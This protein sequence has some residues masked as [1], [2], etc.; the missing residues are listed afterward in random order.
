MAK[1]EELITGLTNYLGYTDEQLEA[2]ENVDALKADVDKQFIRRATAAKDKDF[3]GSIIGNTLGSIQTKLKATAKSYGVEFDADT[4]K[5]ATPEKLFEL[6]LEKLT[7]ASTTALEEMKKQVGSKPSERE[8]ELTEQFEKLKKT[9]SDTTGLLDMTN[10]DFA[11]YKET[12]AREIKNVKLNLDRDK[13][14]SSV[15]PPV[16]ATE[17]Q[18]LGFQAAIN[19]RLKFDYDETGTFQVYDSF[20]HLIPDKKKHGAFLQP[21]EAVKN[22]AVEIGYTSLNPH[23]AKPNQPQQP[24]FV[25]TTTN[26]HTDEKPFASKR[27]TFNP[28]VKK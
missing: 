17:L 5:E 14:L 20:G 6:S 10:K 13:V 19:Q 26:G 16:N 7:N 25:Q 1:K 12:A 8:K 2:F 28:F 24:K 22:L 3:V 23:A 15:T 18:K 9:Y 21:E 27:N 11:S 4:L